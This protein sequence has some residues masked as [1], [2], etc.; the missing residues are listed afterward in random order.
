M[1]ATIIP[2]PRRIIPSSDYETEE[3]EVWICTSPTACER[4]G[5]KAPCRKCDVFFNG[6]HKVR[7]GW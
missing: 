4:F 3:S 2:F 7:N 6:S 1:T 5:V